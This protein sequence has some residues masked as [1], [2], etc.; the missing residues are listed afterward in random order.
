MSSW[1]TF[2]WCQYTFRTS[3]NDI[4]FYFAT[5]IFLFFWDS[6]AMYL[7]IQ[8]G[9]RDTQS[10]CLWN[11]VKVNSTDCVIKQTLIFPLIALSQLKCLCWNKEATLMII[12]KVFQITGRMCFQAT[13]PHLKQ[14]GKDV[15]NRSLGS[16]TAYTCRWENMSHELL[17]I[18]WLDFCVY[19][20]SVSN[21]FICA[22]IRLYQI[23]YCTFWKRFSISNSYTYQ[24]KVYN[25][26]Q[27]MTNYK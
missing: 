13:A 14:G 24:P 4:H 19:S 17:L 26:I 5:T 10:T 7:P 18:P 2:C 20:R 12:C 15:W 23:W 8:M 22:P 16:F 25:F 21:S 27:V 3:V 11:C 9:E 6:S 1:H